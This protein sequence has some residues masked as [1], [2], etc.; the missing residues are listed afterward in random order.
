M[1][2]RIAALAAL[3]VALALPAR[4]DIYDHLGRTAQMRHGTSKMLPP[5]GYD[6][7][8]WRAPNKCDYSRAG[9]PGETVWYLIINTSHRGCPARLV[10]RAFTDYNW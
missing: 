1:M 7:Q 8:R 4:A 2:T 3:A 9:R 5:P 10:E 6:R